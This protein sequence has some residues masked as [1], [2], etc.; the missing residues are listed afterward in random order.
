MRTLA[1]VAAARWLDV[2]FRLPHSQRTRLQRI[3]TIAEAPFEVAL[4]DTIP[5]H[6][7]GG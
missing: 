5:A 7:C 2:S 1:S 4:V 3:R 6:R